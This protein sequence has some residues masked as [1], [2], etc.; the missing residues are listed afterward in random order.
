MKLMKLVLSGFKSFA[1]RTEFEFDDGITCIVGPNGCGK[2]NVVDAFKW[3]LGSQSAKSLRGSEMADVIFNGSVGRRPGGLAEVSLVFDAAGGAPQ[4]PA[5][6]RSAPQAAGDGVLSVTRRLFRSGLSEY[7]V[8]NVPC[9]LRDIRELF[10]DTG[11]GVDAYS[12][13]EQ[14]K[15]EVFLQASQDERRAIFDEAAGISKYK[16]RKKEAL[17]K[18]ERV[19]QNLL[20]LNDIVQEVE[21]QLRS[22]KYQAGKARSYQ[23]Y[24]QRLKEL[25]SLH[26]LAQYHTLTAQRKQLQGRLDA[27]ADALSAI[28]T[29]IDQL[30]TS[31]SASEVE[32]VDLERSARDLQSRIASIGGQI[33][34]CQERSDLLT[35]RVKELDDQILTALARSEELEAKIEAAGAECRQREA[36][37][38]GLQADG[39]KLDGDA[40]AAREQHAAGELALA[41]LR[42]RLEDE[43]DGTVD[44]FRRTAELHNEISHLGLR[45]QSLH[46]Q[47][48]RLVSRVEEI[49]QFL[50]RTLTEKA[51]V[52]A[53]LRDADA[54]VQES[55]QRL[56]ETRAACQRVHDSEQ[57]LRAE[58]A[59]ARERRSALASRIQTLQ[60]MQDRLEG[61]ASGTRRAVEALRAGR[62]R[63]LRGMLG[64]F[65]ATDLPH[66]P[67]VEAALAGADQQLL[68]ERFDE[69]LA[70]A[71]ALR[72][73]LGENAAVEAVCLDRVGPLG[74]DFDAAA[75]P[76]AARRVIDFIRFPAELAPLMWRLLG[77]TLVVE[78]LTDA[79]AAA[80]ATPPGLRFVTR[81]GEVLEA[82]GRLRF[83]AANRAA[84]VIAR[85]SEL[86]ELHAR[87]AD[88]D[89]QIDQLEARCRS[90]RN[91]LAH[92]DKLQQGLRTAIYEAR[93]EQVACKSRLGQL[94]EQVQT[95][96][97]EQ[98]VV[99][100]DLEDLA[101]QIEAT[102]QAEHEAREQA[103]QLEQLNRQRQQEV[104]RIQREIEHAARQQE[105]LAERMT[106]LKVALAAVEEKQRAAREALEAAQR[107][108]EAQRADLAGDRRQIDLDRQRKADAVAAIQK[109]RAEVECLYEQ[110]Q[111]LNREADE[112]EESRSGLKEKLEEIR[113][114]LGERRKAHAAASEALHALKVEQGEMEVRAESLIARASDE[115]G[116]DVL[117][118]YDGYRH[119]ED[120]D[121]DAVD[122]EIQDLR[123]KIERLGN[124]NLDAIAEQDE[125]EKRRDFLRG[126]L[127]DVEASQRRLHELIRRINKES[128]DL[129]L[130]TFAQVKQHFQALFRKLFGGGR[131][132]IVLLDEDNVL[133][134]GIEII[135]RPPGKELRSLS[136]L[137]GGEKTMTALS[138][139]FS[140]FKCRPSPFCLLDEVD[141]ALDEENTARF[142]RLVH[143]FVEGSQFVIISHAKRTI[144]MADSLHGVTMQDPG[145]SKRISVRFEEAVRHAEPPRAEQPQAEAQA[146]AAD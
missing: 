56:E 119:D 32:A 77:R 51:Q 118:L 18:L 104:E 94:G 61:V 95:L 38:D 27:A 102:V 74:G 4:A 70:E 23:A 13:I 113:V 34:T 80:A 26:F 121:W 47:Q 69:L 29:R 55:T 139:M 128:R 115:M 84:G 87:Q 97:R 25:R 91:E 93:T 127:A 67:V 10:M 1:D 35:G 30:E 39:R 101:R 60:E 137:S 65:L 37:L 133:E 81:S 50:G 109:A 90:A 14:G 111:Q 110:Q 48:Q 57:Q 130:A 76:R 132:D 120:R 6:G 63:A 73:V 122:A 41:Q 123:A 78:T 72:E 89:R 125:L 75:C 98:P 64:E 86:D 58:L 99:A 31:Q 106:E 117:G 134:S 105:L 144:G 129:F 54:V 142:V 7:L 21:K 28:A 19:E 126:Q 82:D 92:L 49:D 43:K 44:L 85:R 11:V 100:G 141:A 124:V 146:V 59:E 3:V 145:V 140:F 46:G 22:I 108:A 135:A 79:V 53:K 83:G 116:M 107:R 103:G 15:V 5:H 42:G 2:S 16:A 45:R 66:A 88:C 17:R 52:E 9:R 143:E 36:Q 112:L 138:L 71:G 33:L 12:L 114:Q 40:Q 131:A 20:R 62:L 8:N 96:R 24:A 136:L 68:A